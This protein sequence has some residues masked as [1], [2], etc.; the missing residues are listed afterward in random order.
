M[1]NKLYRFGVALLSVLLL[2]PTS[3][4]LSFP[5][6]SE[7][8][9]YA[10]AIELVSKID[11]M[12]G[13]DTGLFDPEG[14]VTR[15]E[16]ATVICRLFGMDTSHFTKPSN[17]SDCLGHWAETYI[18]AA[19]EKGIVNGYGNGLFGPNDMVTY[20]Q[21]VAMIIRTIGRESEAIYYGG[22]PQGYLT[23]ADFSGL[24]LNL[25]SIVGAN[26]TR[27]EVAQLV[28]NTEMLSDSIMGLASNVV[29][30]NMS[31]SEGTE[32][33]VIT[34][35]DHFG[36]TIWER[37]TN[38]YYATE[39]L[40]ID[41]I[42][43]SGDAYFYSEGGTIVALDL[44]S[45][46]VL[47]TNSDFKGIGVKAVIDEDTIYA[48]GYNGPVFY[49]V[50]TSGKTLARIAEFDEVYR[51]PTNIKL[52]S[53][54]ILVYAA[55]E[56]TDAKG[57]E[58]LRPFYIDPRNWS[59]VKGKADTDSESQKMFGSGD[60][61]YL[62]RL[63]VEHYTNAVQV[64][65]TYICSSAEV[66]LQDDSYIFILRYAMSDREAKELLQ[67]GSSPVANRY[68]TFVAVDRITG[69]VQDEY[70]G[71]RWFASMK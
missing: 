15:G 71:D 1:K 11:I 67:I 25:N 47:W 10:K 38:S 54:K 52:M 28:Y 32:F 50:S 16:M 17:F 3:L 36:T 65:G 23:V 61:D 43:R 30:K 64:E 59:Y 31:G 68:V 62:C 12:V 29:L 40:Q 44:Q 41:E 60:I 33:A 34:A 58:I 20:E 37:T 26:F 56:E 66:E 24:L 19:S 27:A 48:C 63:I 2:V 5:D 18:T 55:A 22:Y 35:K 21:A 39:A 49:A 46:N 42:G 6:V 57:Q 14:F 70:I 7:S 45:G 4:A 53:D 8:S 9:P 69:E 13:R 51:R